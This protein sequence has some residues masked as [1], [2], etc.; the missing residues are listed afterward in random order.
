MIIF[1]NVST[2]RSLEVV[3]S[4][5]YSEML[6][7]LEMV[8]KKGKPDQKDFAFDTR[9]LHINVRDDSVQS[10]L[11][12]GVYVIMKFA[13]GS[14]EVGVWSSESHADTGRFGRLTVYIDTS[15]LGTVDA[16]VWRFKANQDE[17]ESTVV[18]ELQHALDNHRSA[19]NPLYPPGNK[20]AFADKR[21]VDYSQRGEEVPYD[22]YMSFKHE[23]NAR[24]TET[25]KK[26]KDSAFPMDAK[27]FMARFESLFDGWKYVPE[28]QR[29]RLRSRAYQEYVDGNFA[30][31]S[32]N[33][34]QAVREVEKIGL[35]DPKVSLT[36][37]GLIISDFR[38]N[39]GEIDALMV[40][41]KL[42]EL[43]TKLR[44]VIRIEMDILKKYPPL[45]N[46]IRSK[47]QSGEWTRK[48]NSVMVI[49]KR[50]SELNY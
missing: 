48:A 6:A 44:T 23:I 34:N 26:I 33:P 27:T 3:A 14:N 9:E 36:R 50:G 13:S 30:P 25:I 37:S 45:F 49:G 8:A 29:K 47:V 28:D 5:I 10:L 38:F 32:A 24:Y 1:E 19:D 40:V 31:A 11:N 16:V 17:Y 46:V 4:K 7:R 12:D 15:D 18:H 22:V 42:A 35:R 2:Q 41:D 43:S 39:G 20:I 21:I